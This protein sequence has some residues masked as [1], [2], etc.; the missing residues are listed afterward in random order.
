MSKFNKDSVGGTILVVVL[1]SLVCSIIV[2]GSAVALKSTQEEQKVLD[3]QRNIL[4]VAGLLNEDTSSSYIKKTY[5]ELIEPRLVD[6]ATGEY[7]ENVS[8]E[9]I[10]KFDVSSA[11]KDSSQSQ[12]I[13][14]EDDKARIRKR[15]NQARVYLVKDAEGNTT[16]YILPIYGT[17]LWSVMYGFVSVAP[18]ANTINGITY[19]EQGET[20]GLGGEITNPNWQKNFVGKKLFNDEGKY[21]FKVFKAQSTDPVHGVDGLSGATLTANGV[22][23]TFDYW[24]SKNGLGKYL[25]KLKAGAN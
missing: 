13:A 18:D 2:A 3:V 11:V 15:A 4:S 12:N 21:A 1:L 25:E 7:V 6:L 8:R 14:A 9:D 24:F 23:G 17:G 22:Q 20:A 16:Q 5:G 10:E 19:Y